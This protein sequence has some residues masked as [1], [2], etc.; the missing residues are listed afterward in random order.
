[1]FLVF[2]SSRLLLLGN[3]Y[4]N[5]MTSYLCI[6]NVKYQFSPQQSQLTRQVSLSLGQVPVGQVLNLM[7][8]PSYA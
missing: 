6:F 1:M 4:I 5:L 3:C 7:T 2:H 8:L